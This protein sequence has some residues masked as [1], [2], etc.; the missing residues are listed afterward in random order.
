MGKKVRKQVTLTEEQAGSLARA[1]KRL[2]VSEA[3]A[4]RMGIERVCVG[5]PLPSQG[6][7][8]GLW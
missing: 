5:E 7:H 8:S 2:G 1:A 3:E 4:I 6:G